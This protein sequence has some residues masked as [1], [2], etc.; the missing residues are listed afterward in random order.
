MNDIISKKQALRAWLNLYPSC[1]GLYPLQLKGYLD[2]IR[3]LSHLT[4]KVSDNFV[5]NLLYYVSV[6]NIAV[7][8]DKETWEKVNSYIL[9]N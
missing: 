9:E 1:Y 4:T 5:V 3:Y 8:I 6:H 2:V 7:D